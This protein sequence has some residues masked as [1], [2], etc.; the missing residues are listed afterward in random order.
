M[1]AFHFSVL[2]NL[3]ATQL[4]RGCTPRVAGIHKVTTMAQL[5][6]SG[7]HV[8][9]LFAAAADALVPVVRPQAVLE[10]ALAVVDAV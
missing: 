5:E 10:E 2:S 3:R 8:K 4:L 6:V 7:G 1:G 9:Q